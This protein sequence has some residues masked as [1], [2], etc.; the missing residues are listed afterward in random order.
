MTT[1]DT[2]KYVWELVLLVLAGGAAGVG[3]ISILLIPVI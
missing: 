2:H 1:R 3:V